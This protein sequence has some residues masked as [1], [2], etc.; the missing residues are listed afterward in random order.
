M[1]RDFN[2]RNLTE[3]RQGWKDKP[4]ARKKKF[5]RILGFFWFCVRQRWLR[6][7]PRMFSEVMRD[8]DLMVS[9]AHRGVVDPE[10]S[11]STIEMRPALTRETM[12]SLEIANV[13][14]IPI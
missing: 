5:E 6:E 13:R 8:L 9:V 14:L 3:G 7:N 11:A 4:L 2:P 1:L 12:G 10:P